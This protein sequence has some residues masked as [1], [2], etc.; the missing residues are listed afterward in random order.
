MDNDFMKHLEH[1]QVMTPLSSPSVSYLW[2]EKNKT[3]KHSFVGSCVQ[4]LTIMDCM[5]PTS[6]AKG[7][8]VIQEGDDGSMVYVLEGKPGQ[9][10]IQSYKKI[11]LLLTWFFL[12][13]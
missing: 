11:S 5:H 12:P 13:L 2:F 9:S 8:C 4:I 1:G 3:K 6:L 10:S 7:C